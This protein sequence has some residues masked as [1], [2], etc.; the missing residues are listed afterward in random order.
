M[1]AAGLSSN[2]EA[3]MDQYVLV[4]AIF[5]PLM[6]AVCYFAGVGSIRGLAALAFGVPA[7][8]ALW[9]LFRFEGTPVAENGYR[10][11]IEWEDTGLR[12]LGIAFRLGLN[13]IS[14]PLFSLA[15]VVGFA[16]G[17][18]ALHSKLG[19]SRAC[20][21]L[22]ALMQAGLM[23]TFASIDIF[24]FYFAHEL[25]LIPTFVLI[26]LH[27]GRDGRGAA[28]E[29]T[30]YLTLGALLSL[31]GLLALY[32]SADLKSFDLATLADHL[33]T[34]PLEKS[35]QL[36]I[37][38]MLLFGFGI[39]V[40]LFPFHTWAPRGYQAA[41]TPV[42]MLH[43]GVLK[44]FG[45]YGFVQVAAPLLPLGQEGFFDLLVW[46]A[47]GNV[48]LVGLV[49]LSQTEL[50][51]LIGYSSVMHMGY[52]FLGIAVGTTMGISAAVFLMTAHGLA[53]A[54]WFLL[55][56]YLR[57]RTGTTVM[58]KM[59]GLASETP[60][61]ACFFVAATLAVIGLPGFANFWGEFGVFLSM[62]DH[63]GMNGIL[64]L[65]LL[66]ILISTIY[67]LRAIAQILFGESSDDLAQR[68]KEQPIKDLSIIERVPAVL[69]LFAL[70]LVGIWPRTISDHLDAEAGLKFSAESISEEGESR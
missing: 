36:W 15:G 45:L 52:C 1:P 8:A 18:H 61:L 3:Q 46:L 41:P 48:V 33:R 30:I 65:A 9:T 59:G 16:A 44:K 2:L 68:A 67:G 70:V 34:E 69:L 28:I 55:E 58:S 47:L 57:D 35:I 7:L 39:L 64:A 12:R 4:F 60:V 43:A 26:G 32:L 14:L 22:L 38:P 49:A 50:K 24:F 6:V 62:A 53:V 17:W 42:A 51:R 63:G 40:S 54:L 5:A 11:V 29:M 13:G 10:F 56:R 25:A 21:G 19:T 27:G 23:G 31:G 20:M 37:F 66:G